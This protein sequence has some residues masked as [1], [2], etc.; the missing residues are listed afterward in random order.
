VDT[1]GTLA[2]PVY[3][4]GTLYTPRGAGALSALDAVT[5]RELWSL[6]GRQE[7]GA[8]AGSPVVVDGSVVAVR[9][10]NA[11]GE[12]VALDPVAGHVRWRREAPMPVDRLA[13]VGSTVLLYGEGIHAYDVGSGER[14]W[15]HT[16]GPALGLARCTRDRIIIDPG[17][18]MYEGARVV[19]LNAADGEFQWRREP[20]FGRIESVLADNSIVAFVEVPRVDH[21][22]D[23]F[24]GE[25]RGQLIVMRSAH[26]GG[27]RHDQEWSHSVS[28]YDRPLLY[29][30]TV[31]LSDVGTLYAF[32][33]ATGR[34]LWRAEI[35]NLSGVEPFA[36]DDVLIVPCHSGTGGTQLLAFGIN[37]GAPRWPSDT[38]IPGAMLETAVDGIAYC[39]SKRED[40]SLAAIRTSSGE[41]LWDAEVHLE[42]S[43]VVGGGGT[44]FTWGG[45]VDALDARTGEGV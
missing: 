21:D 18:D 11:G 16:A 6:E 33:A 2:A 17:I 4:E 43:G 28:H 13:V 30:G 20:S 41:M 37:D 12:A 39:L 38:V 10:W 42:T 31:Y 34:E 14:L 24:D 22:D 9:W 32:E 44:V 26:G 27:Q 5:A 35:P 19:A 3:H 45:T 29:Q 23:A 36:I 7:Y 1:G 15:T 40:V 25:P 8:R